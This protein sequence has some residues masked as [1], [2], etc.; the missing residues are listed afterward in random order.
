MAA[1]YD[2]YPAYLLPSDD[3]FQ[4]FFNHSKMKCWRLNLISPN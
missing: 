1:A 4:V 2:A 3:V